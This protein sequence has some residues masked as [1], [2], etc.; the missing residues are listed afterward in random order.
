MATEKMRTPA[1]TSVS[2]SCG[3]KNSGRLKT[4][5]DCARKGP[6]SAPPHV[7]GAASSVLPPP[8]SKLAGIAAPS[9][10]F[11]QAK[12]EVGRPGPMRH[13]GRVGRVKIEEFMGPR[14]WPHAHRT[15]GL[16]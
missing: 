1:E 12:E 3:H 16:S 9:N 13:A 2:A 6:P 11:R 4:V 8:S 15:T 14:G 10:G 7:H 5:H